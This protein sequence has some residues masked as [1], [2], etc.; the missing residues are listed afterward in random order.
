MIRTCS[1]LEAGLK[2]SYHTCGGHMYMWGDHMIP[3][4]YKIRGDYQLPIPY[5][6]WGTIR[7][8]DSYKVSTV[9]SNH[10]YTSH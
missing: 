9:D 4:L 3:V 5:K 1:G 8:I 6:V 10:K 2:K 7:V